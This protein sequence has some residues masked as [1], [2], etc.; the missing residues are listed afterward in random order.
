MKR[1]TLLVTLVGLALTGCMEPVRQDAEALGQGGETPR[2]DSVRQDVEALKQ[3]Q[4]ALLKD[5]AEIKKLLQIGGEEQ[6]VAQ[7]LDKV[8]EISGAPLKGSQDA[9]LTLIEFSDY[10]CP[11]CKRHAEETL[12]RIDKEYIATGKLRY[13]FRDFPLEMHKQAQ[14]AAEA[15]HCADEQGKYWEIHDRLF[16][17]QQALKP[18]QL[19]RYARAAGLQT[20][21]FKKCLDSG[22]YAGQVRKDIAEGQKLGING[23]PTLMLGVS[24]GDKVENVK[25]IQGAHPFPTFKEEIDKLLKGSDQRAENK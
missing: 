3:S 11:F 25:M 24:N 9:K 23:T 12:S 20:G 5:M 15:A 10:Q 8:L 16:A 21:P 17:N 4:E 13:V 1:I 14:K 6:P 19:I 18:K 2:K 22:K 7:A